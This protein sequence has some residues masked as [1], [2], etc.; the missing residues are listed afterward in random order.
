MAGT[1]SLSSILVFATLALLVR[2]HPV[3]ACTAALLYLS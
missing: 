1:P 2:L 3:C